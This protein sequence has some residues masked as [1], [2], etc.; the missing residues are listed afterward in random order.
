MLGFDLGAKEL[1]G[2]LSH[3]LSA[4]VAVALG[5]HGGAGADAQEVLTAA[6]AQF[7]HQNG[8]IGPLPTAIGV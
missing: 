2:D 8:D 6:L 1:A 5:G 4:I 3:S 7:A